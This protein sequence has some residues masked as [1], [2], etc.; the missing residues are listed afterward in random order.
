MKRLDPSLDTL[1]ELDGTVFVL[2]SEAK[3]WVSFV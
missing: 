3:Y 1:L 2:D